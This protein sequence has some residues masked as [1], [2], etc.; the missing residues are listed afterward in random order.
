MTLGSSVYTDEDH[1]QA[2]DLR[3]PVRAN[4]TRDIAGIHEA[5]E[6]PMA[7]HEDAPSACNPT[8]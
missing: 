1:L 5:A 3:A 6:A 2:P 8:E 7:S 4:R